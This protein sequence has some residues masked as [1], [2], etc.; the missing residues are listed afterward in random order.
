MSSSRQE[1]TYLKKELFKATLSSKGIYITN[2]HSQSCQDADGDADDNDN[3]SDSFLLFHDDEASLRSCFA[4][5]Y[6]NSS[7]SSSSASTSTK[8]PKY[9]PFK[10]II[11][12]EARP[13]SSSSTK[14]SNQVT[15]TY[16]IPDHADITTKA[17]KLSINKINVEIEDLQQASVANYIMQKAYS[18]K[19]MQQCSILVL[20]NPHGGQGKAVQIY[21]NHIKPILQ[22]AH[23]KIT[24]QE[25]E[26]SGHAT[27]IARELDIDQY[28]VIACCSG[29][30]IPHEV[31]NG[32]YQR[33]RDLGVA[34][35]NKL[36]ITQLPC[37]SGNAFSLSTLGGSKY[38]EIATWLMLKSKPTKID[39]MA[40]TQGTGERMN[41]KLSFLS[42]CYGII[43]DSDIGTEHLRWLGSI[44]FDIGV[45][46]RVFSNAKYPCDL[47]VEFWSQNKTEIAQHVEQHLSSSDESSKT[48]TDDEEDDNEQVSVATSDLGLHLVTTKDLTTGKANLDEPVPQT[49][50]ALPEEICKN[51]NILYVGKM[52]YVSS[53]AQFFP[54]ALPN[55]GYMDMIITDAHHTSVLSLTS[56]LLN[57]EKGK[58]IDDDAVLHAKIKAYRLVP[59]MTDTKDHYISVDGESFPFE[60][61]Q[62]EILPNVMTG[63]LQDGKFTETVLTRYSST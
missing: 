46:Q 49:W 63:L 4:C 58:H 27:D 55:D 8:Q 56:I 14:R 24:L 36:I 44:R 20:I 1:P 23:C 15:V 38:P 30:G 10:N 48:L 17:T 41:T 47:Y 52:P 32:F 29:D 53:D 45:I 33:S 61:F 31:I 12:A 62:V 51:L 5:G 26:Y 50:Q 25:T 37:G 9:V 43:A 28:D 35:F 57:V 22:A 13:A 19:T 6:N 59:R 11:Y 21:N 7:V 54:A 42:Q 16:V 3:G 39:L 34:A 40:I 18:S 2:Q 60:S